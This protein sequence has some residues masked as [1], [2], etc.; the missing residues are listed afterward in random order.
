MVVPWGDFRLQG[1]EIGRIYEFDKVKVLVK[2]FGPIIKKTN[3]EK[4]MLAVDYSLFV[5]LFLGQILL[6]AMWKVNTIVF[7]LFIGTMQVFSI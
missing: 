7:L 5:V 2:C 6:V 4:K 3:L 1:L